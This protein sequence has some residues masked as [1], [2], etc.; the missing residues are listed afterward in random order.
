M[1]RYVLTTEAQEDLRKICDYLLSESGA[2]ATRYVIGAFVLAFRR[3][4]R[5]PG[6]G[7]QR[8]DLTL[9]QTLLFWPVF[10]YLIVYRRAP[11]H[12][13]IVALLNS[14]RDIPAVLRQRSP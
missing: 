6:M 7:H 11:G 2:R 10:S 8:E 5:R 14:K 1:K 9:N 12:V 13:A 4:A 3:L